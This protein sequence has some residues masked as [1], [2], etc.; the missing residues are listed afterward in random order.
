MQDR[1]LKYVLILPAALLVLGTTIWPLAVSL[2]TSF[3]DWR[4]TRSLTPGPFIGSEHYV[5]ALTDD[6]DFLNALQVTASFVAIDVTLTVVCA[7]GLALLLRRAGV[8]HSLT[9]AVLI[10][11]FAVSPALVGISFRFMFNAEMGVFT[12]LAGTLVP[13]LK[14][15]VWLGDPVASLLVLVFSDAW[16]WVPYMTL[17]VLGG[18]SALPREPEEAAR[19]DGASEWQVLRDV[20]LP[21]LLPV[22]AVVAIL[23]TVFALKMFDQVVTLTG[24]GPGQSTTTL[25]YLVYSIAFR[26]YDMGYASAVAWILTAMLVFLAVWYMK[27]ILRKPGGA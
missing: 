11:P 10:L 13:W 19:I 5:T 9:R 23:K 25:A 26:W 3:R 15:Y 18:L 7:L 14:G 20:T 17:V 27:L 21:A 4:L 24:G 16:R 1:R 22:L 8:L 12:W 6:P 2:V